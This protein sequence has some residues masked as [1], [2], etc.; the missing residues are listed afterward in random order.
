MD[1]FLE[2][3]TSIFE[4]LIRLFAETFGDKVVELGV[5]A[6]EKAV[7]WLIEFLASDEEEVPVTS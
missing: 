3:S 5:T 6:F 1:E 7:A 2:K 4:Q